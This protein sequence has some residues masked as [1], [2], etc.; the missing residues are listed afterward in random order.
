M[1][2]PSP[3]QWKTLSIV[4]CLLSALVFLAGC[5]K[6]LPPPEQPPFHGTTL[7]IACPDSME[8]TLRPQTKAW[9]S[10]QN[11]TVRLL[12]QSSATPRYSLPAADIWILRPAE[13][14]HW[15]SQQLLQPL[16]QSLQNRGNSFDW[17]GLLPLYREQLL[18]WNGIPFGLPILGE[19]PILLYREDLLTSPEWK[20]RLGNWAVKTQG[21]VDLRAPN[22]WEELALLAEFFRDHHPL[23][24]PGPS[25]PPLPGDP[26][27]LDQQFYQVAAPFARR[28]I[29]QDEPQK[30]D[31]L[32][33]VFAFHYDLTSGAPR[34]DGPGFVAALKLLQRLQACRPPGTSADPLSAFLEG[35]AVFA[36]TGASSLPRVQGVPTLRDK[37]G[38]AAIPGTLS[39]F[40]PTGQQQTLAQG[41]NRVPYLGGSGWVAVVPTSAAN[42]DAAWNFL[43]DLCSGSR[44]SDIVM[45]PNNRGGPIRSEQ[46]LR[47]R[48]DVFELNPARTLT[49][50]DSVARTILQHGLK[51]PV[52]CLRIPDEANHLA[53]MT[54]ALRRSL[55]DKA[56]AAP[57]LKT[58]ADRWRERDAKTG[59]TAFLGNY[60]IS[61]G[62]RGSGDGAP[63]Q[64]APASR[65]NPGSE[66]KADGKN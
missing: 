15:A 16:P 33:E 51:N 61:L 60:R 12:P 3:L 30:A 21:K 59:Q 37:V 42:P 41:V 23:G 34:I 43:A 57:A 54:D 1:H 2:L 24:K 20:V 26:Y 55:L 48:W 31:H 40:T 32:A 56:E 27:L 46:L 52:L 11:A 39:Y 44:S 47:D 18:V 8:A 38:I 65:D 10:R 6:E 66:K 35:Q 62:L 13:L 58:V 25:L 17:N 7:Q 49:L 19:S 9:S 45:E 64:P 29:R 4:S 50:R 22:S 63:R 28:S 53:D 14:P 36:I 5:R